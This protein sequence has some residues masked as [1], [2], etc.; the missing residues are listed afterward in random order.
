MESGSYCV[1]CLFLPYAPKQSEQQVLAMCLDEQRVSF[2]NR[3]NE[4]ITH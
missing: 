3:L 2:V 4:R 1:F